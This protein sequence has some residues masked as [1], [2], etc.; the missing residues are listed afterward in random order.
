M[1]RTPF[2]YTT[3]PCVWNS[4]DTRAEFTNWRDEVICRKHYFME[5]DAIRNYLELTGR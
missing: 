2:I 4:C 1:T 3:L 5:I